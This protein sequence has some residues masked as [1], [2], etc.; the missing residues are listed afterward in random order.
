MISLNMRLTVTVGLNVMDGDRYKHV[1]LF[2][3]S[4]IET[5]DFP[6]PESPIRTT[7]CK[8]GKSERE[9]LEKGDIAR[10]TNKK[11]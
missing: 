5:H 3:I 11:S 7:F 4:S 8:R 10:L 9:A 6:T 1:R 2:T